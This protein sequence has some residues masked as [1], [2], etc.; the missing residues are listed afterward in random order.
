MLERPANADGT[1]PP[2]F[3]DLLKTEV[4]R[5]AAALRDNQPFAPYRL[6]GEKEEPPCNTSSVT[7]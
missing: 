3:R 2:G 6:D 4:E 1:T 7:I 5:L